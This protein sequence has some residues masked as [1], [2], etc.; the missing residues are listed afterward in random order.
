MLD[1]SCTPQQLHTLP[2]SRG[3]ARGHWRPA[4]DA[5]IAQDAETRQNHLQSTPRP[6]NDISGRHMTTHERNAR[7]TC[8]RG[9][10]ASSPRR[11]ALQSPFAAL[12]TASRRPAQPRR[13]CRRRSSHAAIHVTARKNSASLSSI[14]IC[15]SRGRPPSPGGHVSSPSHF[16]AGEADPAKI[17]PKIDF[18][19]LHRTE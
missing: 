1:V 14:V 5:L 6:E 12:R 4:R 3:R 18:P 7:R 11:G 19:I 15:I 13:Q 10:N 2:A 16:C 8:Q 9:R 17:E